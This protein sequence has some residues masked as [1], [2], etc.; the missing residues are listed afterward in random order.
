MPSAKTLEQKKQIVKELSEKIAK[1]KTIVIADYR[2]ITV[3][4]DTKL[5]SELRKENVE[6][7]IVKNTYTLLAAK[8]NG[9]EGLEEYLNGPTSIAFGFDDP[10]APARLLVNYSKSNKKFQIKAGVLEGKVIS[11]QKLAELANLPSREV[12][13][14]KLLGTINAPVSGLV[15]VLNANI[16]GVV[17]AL[18]AIAEQKK[19]A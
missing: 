2:G 9:L 4:E 8:Q 17:V 10:V 11:I 13:V 12:L 1:A 18:N 16:R 6:Y 14:A 3:A 5:R 15:N 19:G 7:R